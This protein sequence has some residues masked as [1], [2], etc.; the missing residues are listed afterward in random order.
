MTECSTSDPLPTFDH[1]ELVEAQRADP[2][3][4]PVIRLKETNKTLTDKD[5]QG[6]NGTTRKMMHEWSR[7]QI[8]NGL[9]YRKTSQRRQFVLPTLYKP[10]F[11]TFSLVFAHPLYILFMSILFTIATF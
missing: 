3:I 2:I 7:L 11:C 8:E 6:V 9:L 10:D 5:R 4:G 1:D